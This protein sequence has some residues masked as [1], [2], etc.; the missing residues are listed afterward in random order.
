MEKA[1]PQ[2]TIEVLHSI[3]QSYIETG[4][5]VASRAIARFRQRPPQPRHYPQHHGGLRRHRLS[6]SAAH[7]RRPRPH[8]EG[9]PPLR[10][11]VSARPVPDPALDVSATIWT[12][13]G[14]DRR[15]EHASHILSEMTHNVSIVAA[16]PASAQTL[17]QIEL[18]RLPER[19][20]LMVVVTR[21]GLVHN[22]VV[23]LENPSPRTNSPPSV[24]TSTS[25]FTGWV[26]TAI[27]P[28]LDRRLQAEE[29]GLRP[30]PRRLT[31]LYDK[32]LLDIGLTPPGSTSR[33]PPTSSASTS[34]SPRRSSAISSAPWKRRSAFIAS[35]RSFPGRRPRPS[36]GA[37]RPGG[38]ASLH[39]PAFA[40]RRST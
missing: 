21:D 19:R 18:V 15:A 4:E 23:K 8:R 7:L 1:L 31:L 28:E 24:T 13:S 37:G 5:P 3:V 35:A 30:D 10:P 36:P 29:R 33:A 27:R 12:T 25:N 38:R 11:V 16:I 32:G 34:T 22:Q 9:L 26:L 39:A 6:R 40:H 20:V 17:D 2:R 14:L